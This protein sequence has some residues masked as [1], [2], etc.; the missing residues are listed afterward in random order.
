METLSQTQQHLATASIFDSRGARTPVIARA[1]PNININ[2]REGITGMTNI[3]SPFEQVLSTLT[4]GYRNIPHNENIVIDPRW[5][6]VFIGIDRSGSMWTFSQDQTRNSVLAFVD[7]LLK[8][9]DIDKISVVLATFDDR[10]TVVFDDTI[11]DIEELSQNVPV[12]AFTPRGGTC[13]TEASA[14]LAQYGGKKLAM[15]GT[16]IGDTRP[17]EPCMVI[18][19]DGQ[20]N[21]SQGKWKGKDG[22]A[23]LKSMQTELTDK[24]GWTL[25]MMGAN[26]DG[27]LE[28]TSADMGFNRFIE[29]ET[30][31]QGF[32]S[33]MR[34]CSQA[35]S[36]RR[37][38]SVEERHQSQN[39]T[40]P[41]LKR[42]DSATYS[43]DDDDDDDDDD[44]ALSA[45]APLFRE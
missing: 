27:A 38:F 13:L 2:I 35:Y 29:L 1:P 17:S 6:A 22:L 10:F 4:I 5:R 30:S 42:Q 11:T 34:S 25:Q 37:D 20:E 23:A 14:T 31:D 40:P 33:A 3:H 21:Q 44:D 41:Q 36:E 18:M 39:A 15:Y 28:A 16:V 45:N 12:H 43:N 32:D 7:E 9:D 26:Q 24:W 19:T 8:K